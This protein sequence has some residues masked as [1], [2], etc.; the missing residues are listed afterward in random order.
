MFNNPI[1]DSCFVGIALLRKNFGLINEE[2]INN[3]YWWNLFNE[4]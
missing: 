1:L 4:N 3:I 2:Y